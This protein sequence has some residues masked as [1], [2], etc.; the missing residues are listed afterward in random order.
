MRTAI[1]SALLLAGPAPAVQDAAR[2]VDFTRDVR[3]ILAQ[4][5]LLCH[6]P[7]AKVRKADLRLDTP[8]GA[9]AALEGGRR[10]VVPG[11]PDQSELIKRITTSDKDD[12]MP[13]SKTGKTLTPA[14][15]ETL[16]SWI[17]QGAP[18]A[19]HWAFVKPVRPAVPA[20]KDAAWPKNDIDRFI[21][22]RLEHEGLKPS[23]EADRR[24]PAAAP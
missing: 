8:E 19:K 2:K 5:C 20:V 9:L 14:Q 7:D 23:P 21:L 6:G 4:N 17:A 3:P 22:A 18:Y 11:K 24:R 16:R 10:A 13:P 15:V 12:V 1:L